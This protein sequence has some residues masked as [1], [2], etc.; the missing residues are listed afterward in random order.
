MIDVPLEEIEPVFGEM[1]SCQEKCIAWGGQP[2]HC[3]VEC[4]EELGLLWE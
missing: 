1:K 2:D 4:L 3:Y